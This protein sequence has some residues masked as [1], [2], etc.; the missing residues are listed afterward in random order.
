MESRRRLEDAYR[1]WLRSRSVLAAVHERLDGRRSSRG[2][3]VALENA[4]MRGTLHRPDADPALLFANADV[5]GLVEGFGFTGLEGTEAHEAAR[6]IRSTIA[7]VWGEPAPELPDDL[8]V[9]LTPDGVEVGEF[10]L[11]RNRP[12]DRLLTVAIGR[13]GPTTGLR[14]VAA[15]ALRYAAIYARTRHIGPP[16]VVYDAFH[17][18]GVR[19]EG[20]ASPFNSRLIDRED[21]GYCSAFPELDAP[22]GSRGSFFDIDPGAF[23]GAW[24]LDPPFIPETMKRVDAIIRAW[25]ERTDP[26]TVLLIVPMSYT[27]D[28][29]VDETVVLK[30]GVHHYTGLDGELHPLPVDVGIHR[31][32]ELPGF[33][34]GVIQDGYLPKTSVG[35]PVGEAHTA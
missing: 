6:I 18:W 3:E 14:L 23:P 28:V 2:A 34:A 33:D 29:P 21:S 13:H 17:R 9:S 4:L 12:V 24:C 5:D 1:Q 25:R 22:L 32:G 7:D 30:A 15:S 20:F 8:R 11:D 26:V 31:I 27:P 19:N 35:A 16:Q 10:R